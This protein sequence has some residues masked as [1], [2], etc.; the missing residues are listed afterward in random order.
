MPGEVAAHR[1]L[2][3][4]ADRVLPAE[5][6]DEV[7]ARVADGPGAQLSDQFDDVRTE[8]VVVRARVFRLV[9]PCL[10]AAAEVFDERAEG[11]AW[12]RGDDGLLV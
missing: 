11:A 1:A 3:A 6:G 9:E 7:A 10:H 8:P 4:G 5:A 12:D 2:V